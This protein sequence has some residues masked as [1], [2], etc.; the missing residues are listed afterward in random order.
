MML[1]NNS[2]EYGSCLQSQYTFCIKS[3]VNI[4]FL[5]VTIMVGECGDGLS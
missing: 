5:S 1:R 4:M 2:H 3:V